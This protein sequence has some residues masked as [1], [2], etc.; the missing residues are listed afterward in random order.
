MQQSI[1][2][3]YGYLISYGID[4]IAA[5]FI[6]IVGKWVAKTASR[7]VE[8]MLIRTHVDATVAK[9][10]KHVS[11]V[12]FMAF[13]IIAALSKVGVQTT[14]L[15]A[16][17]GAAGLAVGLALQGSLSNFAAGVI[18]VLFKPFKVGDAIEA[19][20]TMGTVDEIQI[21]NTVI[22]APDNRRVIVPNAKITGDNITN[23]TDIEHRRIDLKFGISYSND[24]RKA[25]DLL[26]GLVKADPR[27]L[28][29]PEPVVAVSELA[30]NSVNLVCRPWV[31]PAVYWDVY[32][33][34]TE[35]GKK[36][37]EDNG[38]V[39]PFPQHEVYLYDQRKKE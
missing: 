22:N 12:A 32:F 39:I 10:V 13:V 8:D 15:V 37:L 30:D 17:I 14:S 31:K 24:M 21:F 20:G 4:L 34:L 25:K 6:F 19:G 7:L 9:F 3:I 35:K 5:I 1:D 16:I 33:D 27:I 38:M 36:V 18:L 29:Y 28:K 26:M 2:K 11:Y 23:F